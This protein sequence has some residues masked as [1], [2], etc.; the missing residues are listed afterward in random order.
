[1]LPPTSPATNVTCHLCNYRCSRRKRLALHARLHYVYSFCRCGYGSKWRETIRKHQT[2][3]RNDCNVPLNTYPGEV[4]TRVIQQPTTSASSAFT[5][6]TTATSMPT[7][8][9]TSTIPARRSSEAPAPRGEVRHHDTAPTTAPVPQ[10]TSEHQGR[11][12]NKGAKALRIERKTTAV[13]I[14]AVRP[15]PGWN[16]DREQSPV[17]L[18]AKT[19]GISS[20]PN[21]TRHPPPLHDP[22]TRPPHTPPPATSPHKRNPVTLLRFTLARIPAIT[23][24]PLWHR[25]PRLLLTV[26]PLPRLAPLAGLTIHTSP[27]RSRLF[28]AARVREREESGTTS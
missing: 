14:A 26:R 21:A 13:S 20:T 4:P 28:L 9:P 16:P 11:K 6:T 10:P 3:T 2:N 8:M 27:A 25:N 7:S 5:T 12:H 23:G 18:P 19:P 15:V 24:T 22:L 1:M 17:P